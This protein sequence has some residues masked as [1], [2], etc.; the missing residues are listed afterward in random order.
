[1]GLPP[2]TPCWPERAP[3]DDHHVVQYYRETQELVDGVGPFAANALTTGAAA[4]LVATTAHGRAIVHALI[5]GGVDVRAAK[6]AGRLVVCD[7]DSLLAGFAGP[8]GLDRD[9]FA[10]AVAEVLA[11]AVRQGLPLRIFGEMVALL[12]ERGLVTE[13]LELE[14]MWN[15]L[16]ADV[17]FD[18][19]CA[20]PLPIG[21]RVADVRAIEAVCDLHSALCGPRSPVHGSV[22][23]VVAHFPSDL[24]TADRVR[25]LARSVFGRWG[26]GSV[27][28]DAV[29][30][31]SELATNALLHAA[32]GFMLELS[33]TPTAVR[34]SVRD[35]TTDPPVRQQRALDA[36]SGRGL[37]LID[38]VSERWGHDPAPSGKLV[39]AE[40]ALHPR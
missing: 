23:P 8:D 27:V 16:R 39:W 30:V 10:A 21:D 22:S 2:E 26:L 9:E 12:W 6:Q 31:I 34:V 19:Y 28:D 18:L 24:R 32:T 14:T 4:V 15:H 40:L 17:P 33:L 25:G 11:P 3:A 13:A 7:A 29:L 38:A 20:Y 5:A 35:A 36:V 37:A 1:M